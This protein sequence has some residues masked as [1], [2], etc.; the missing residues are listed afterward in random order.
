MP[1]DTKAGLRT[2]RKYSLQTEQ[3]NTRFH[4]KALHRIVY[5]CSCRI[6]AQD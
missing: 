3:V 2:E 5:K 4:K 6:F 1:P